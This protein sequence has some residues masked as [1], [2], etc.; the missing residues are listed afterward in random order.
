MPNRFRRNAHIAGSEFST[1]RNTNSL[2]QMLSD[3]FRFLISARLWL[4]ILLMALVSVFLFGLAVLFLGSYTKHGESITVPSFEGMTLEQVKEVIKN[5]PLKYKVN[6]TVYVKEALPMAVIKQNPAPNQKVK[7]NRRIYL[8]INAPVPPMT[9]VPE[10]N[11]VSLKQARLILSSVGLEEGKLTYVSCVGK[12]VVKSASINGKTIE[13]TMKVRKGTQVDLVLCEGGGGG[14]MEV[15]DLTGMAYSEAVQFIRMSDLTLGNIELEGGLTNETRGYVY[16]QSP[17]P[18]GVNTIR[19]GEPIDLILA[20]QGM[21]RERQYENE[22]FE[23][24]EEEPW[25]PIQETPKTQKPKP[26][27][28]N[29]PKAL[30]R[31]LRQQDSLKVVKNAAA[32]KAKGILEGEKEEGGKVSDNET[33]SPDPAKEK[34]DSKDQSE[35]KE[36]ND[37]VT[38]D[39]KEDEAKPDEN[40][41]EP[42]EEDDDN[43]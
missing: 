34:E 14:S 10:L 29:D 15:E 7:E 24:E 5:K 32:E 33:L 42:A 11:D 12:N 25:Q 41:D 36:G 2:H 17:E 4:N 8:T 22:G 21:K 28:F 19:I 40:N 37:P 13:K 39:N 30:E 35:P 31:L 43:R 3:F 9:K 6:D 38:P 1:G 20:P 23:E 26:L 27:D 16:A 18:N